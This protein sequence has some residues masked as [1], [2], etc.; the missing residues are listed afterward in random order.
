F[1]GGLGALAAF[2]ALLAAAGVYAVTAHGVA[3]RRRE[4]G[5]RM[6]LGARPGQVVWLLLA[7]NGR[8]VRFGAVAGAALAICLERALQLTFLG[9][10]PFVVSNYLG[11]ALLLAAAAFAATWVPARRAARVDPAVALHG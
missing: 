3:R 5:V 10:R 8:L 11:A 2:A 7:Q 6:A 1:A 4:I 9:M